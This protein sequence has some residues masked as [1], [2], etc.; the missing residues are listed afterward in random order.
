MPTACAAPASTGEAAVKTVGEAAMKT[1]GEAAVKTVAEATTKTAAE[2]AMKTVG[3]AAAKTVAEATVKAV[4]EVM[5][6]TRKSS[7][8]HD[9]G[10]EPEKPRL[11]G[12][13]RV[14]KRIG[15]IV[16]IRIAIGIFGRRGNHVDLRRQSRRSLGDPP[17]P[18]GLLA[19][20]DDGLLLLSAYPYRDDVA[21]AGWLVGRRLRDVGRVRCG[22]GGRRHDI[23]LGR[24]AGRVL[25]DLPATVRLLTRPGICLLRPCSD[26]YRRVEV[27]A[28]ELR[29]VLRQLRFAWRRCDQHRIWL[30]LA[31]CARQDHREGRDRA[32]GSLRPIYGAG[33]RRFRR[34]NTEHVREANRADWANRRRRLRL[35]HRWSVRRESWRT[36]A[37]GLK[38]SSIIRAGRHDAMYPRLMRKDYKVGLNVTESEVDDPDAQFY[39]NYK[40]GA[41]CNYSGYCNESVEELIDRQSREMSTDKRR[42]LV[43]QIERQLIEEDARPDIFY[44]RGITC[45]RPYVK[46][47][48]SM[49][50]SIYNG[51]RFENVWL[52]Q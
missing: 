43:W 1:V 20:L 9:S 45:R 17:A 30:G 42:Q 49:V 46:D 12:P 13:I 10:P 52:D 19:G 25:H 34:T 35:P 44:V 48:I 33:W 41:L 26:R 8:H 31:S 37:L 7:R 51:S 6:E 18:I 27:A 4:G 40:C 36:A 16:R 29:F 2:A 15:I 24:Q 3:E 38:A 32:H 39:E 14:I 11:G 5:V 47:L 22:L 23:R 21:G 50:N 28:V